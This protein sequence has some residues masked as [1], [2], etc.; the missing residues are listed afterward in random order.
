MVGIILMIVGGAGLILSLVF[1]SSVGGYG[2]A[3]RETYV[4]EDPY[5]RRPY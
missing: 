1:W 4:R 2:I 3:R 5:D